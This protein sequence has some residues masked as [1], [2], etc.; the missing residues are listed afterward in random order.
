MIQGK[1]ISPFNKPY[2]KNYYKVPR[3]LDCIAHCLANIRH[4][5]PSHTKQKERVRLK[6]MSKKIIN[7]KIDACMLKGNMRAILGHKA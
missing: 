1:Y 3:L 6:K 5:T 4:G 2:K 7:T